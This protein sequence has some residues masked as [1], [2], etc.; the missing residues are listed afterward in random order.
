MPPRSNQP[1]VLQRDHP[2]PLYQQLET[3]LRAQI[4]SG[5][6][7]EHQRL[8]SERELVDQFGVSRMTVRQALVAL[9]QEGLIYGRVGKGTFISAPKIDQQFFA[10][11]GFTEDIQQRGQQP[12]SRVLKAVSQ[13][14]SKEVAS[15]LQIEPQT[16]VLNLV[17]LRLA[18]GIP[19]AIE[20]AFLPEHLCPDLLTHDLAH[21]SL[22][23]VLRN[24]YGWKLVRARQTIEARLAAG[25]ELRLLGIQPPAPVLAL[26]RIT[27]VSENLPIEYVRSQYRGDRYKFTALVTATR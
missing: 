10:L 5:R 23:D 27:F 3:A 1:G 12:S 19:L 14:A 16:R 20:C 18:D 21:E 2:I 17:R 9:T 8:P 7:A 6:Y 22:Y 13:A 4:E 24:Q 25:E 15:A 11:T 26:E